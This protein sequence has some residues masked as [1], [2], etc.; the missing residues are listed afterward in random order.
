MIGL[1]ASDR[2]RLQ[3]AAI[4][5]LPAPPA[6]VVVAIVARAARAVTLTGDNL[7]AL[8]RVAAGR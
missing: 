4:A 5:T 1:G 7:G 3:A 8:L 6:M 2:L